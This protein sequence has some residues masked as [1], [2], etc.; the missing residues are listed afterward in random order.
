MWCKHC[1]FTTSLKAPVI[2][3]APGFAKNE[4]SAAMIEFVDIFPTLSE[5]CDLD[6]PE[7]D[8]VAVI[9]QQYVTFFGLSECRPDFIF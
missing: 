6:I 1:N 4:T 3:K 8:L 7:T 9:L 5:L 2:I